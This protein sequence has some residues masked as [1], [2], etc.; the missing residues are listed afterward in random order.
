MTKGGDIYMKKAMMLMVALL[1]G[2]SF[3]A[4]TF[5][6]EGGDK[7]KDKPKTEKPKDPKK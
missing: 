4:M 1:V 2:L 7:G 5:A 6:G 3:G